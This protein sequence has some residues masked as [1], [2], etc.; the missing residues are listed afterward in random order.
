MKPW[1]ALAITVIA[2][3]VVF[4][5]LAGSALAFGWLAMGLIGL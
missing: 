1:M 4:T 3:P 2:A 5:V